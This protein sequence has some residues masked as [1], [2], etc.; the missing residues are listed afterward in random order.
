MPVLLASLLRRWVVTLS[1]LLAV[2]AVGYATVRAVP[3]DYKAE[4]T[5]LLVPPES[6]DDPGG[7]RFLALG[8]LTPA[9]DV[10]LESL[11][12]DTV[13]KE[14][15]PDPTV[16]YEVEPDFTTS[17]PFVVVTT[18]AS[19]PAAADDLLT[20]VV[21]EV[22]TLLTSLQDDISTRD[23]VRITSV[24][25]SHGEP[26]RAGKKQVRAVIAATGG[27]LVAG[28]LGIGLLDR[29]L[30]RRRRRPGGVQG[31]GG[32]AADEGLEAA[33]DSTLWGGS[34][35]VTASTV[36][37]AASVPEAVT[38]SAE[39]EDVQPEDPDAEEGADETEQSRPAASAPAARSA[40]PATTRPAAPVPIK[41]RQSRY[42]PTVGKAG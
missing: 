20:R 35:V 6:A 10:I 31:D 37:E 19:T 8:G 34:R 23:S 28:V 1:L 22:P 15:A 42:A 32:P 41:R 9:R 14:L 5:V 12:S 29:W 40:K 26:E 33:A 25:V 3:P 7:N 36:H 17:T 11:R 18:T 38:D 24:E 30:T 4:G 39:H 21:A 16:T 13:R 2:G 27:S